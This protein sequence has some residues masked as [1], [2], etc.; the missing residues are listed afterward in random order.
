MLKGHNDRYNKV[1]GREE[2]REA[3]IEWMGWKNE[4]ELEGGSLLISRT[5]R[6]CLPNQGVNGRIR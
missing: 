6:A 5:G 4:E 1:Q 2:T 3:K